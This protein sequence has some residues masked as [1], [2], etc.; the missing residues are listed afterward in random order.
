MSILC[1]AVVKKNGDKKKNGGVANLLRHDIIK[2]LHIL[3]D[4]D[5]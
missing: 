3:V 4:K 1:R 2:E 5:M